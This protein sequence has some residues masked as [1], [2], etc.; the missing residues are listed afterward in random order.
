MKHITSFKGFLSK[1]VNLNKTQLR[2]LNRSSSAINTFLRENLDLYEKTERQ[3][4][5]G[6]QTIIKPVS[7]HEYDVDMLLYMTHDTNKEPKDYI[8]EVYNCLKEN[9]NYKDKVRRKTRCV[10]IDY[11]GNFHLDLVPCIRQQNW[12]TQE[13]K[14]FICNTNNNKFEP[15]D[16]TGYRDWFN[17]KTKITNGDL[18]RVAR[19]LK[20]LRDHKGNFSVKSILLT[21]LIGN[22]IYP[23][24]EDSQDFED[25]PTSLKTVSNR[26]NDFL[27]NN[28]WMPE[29]RNPVLPTESFTRHWDQNKYRN[30]REKFNIYNDKINDAF[31]APEHD[32]SVKKWRKLFGANFGKLTNNN[33]D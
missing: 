33:S 25:L 3:G 20:F 2:R 27:Q 23:S 30:F 15:T 24:D 17:E 1:E 29:I 8:N 6:L 14:S 4:S 26:I 9:D 31:D 19:L 22:N 5:Y 32:A 28:V 16:G 10:H 21:T 11:A 13:E 18:K 7:S 12:I